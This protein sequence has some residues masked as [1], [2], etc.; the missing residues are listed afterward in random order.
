MGG[1]ENAGLGEWGGGAGF[2]S[3]DRRLRSPK[4]TDS[5]YSIS[6]GHARGVKLISY[7]DYHCFQT[8]TALVDST[9]TLTPLNTQ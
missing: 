1:G 3:D 6:D 8:G 5:K 9:H 2:A 4:S 7:K